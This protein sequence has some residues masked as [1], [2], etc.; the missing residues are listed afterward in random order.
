MK[1]TL[2]K[3][4]VLT[5]LMVGGGVS[6]AQNGGAPA[7]RPPY[8]NNNSY[9]N[10]NRPQQRPRMTPEQRQEQS[11][12][13]LRGVMKE[14]GITEEADQ[15]AVLAYLSDE[16]EARKPLRQM[17]MKLQGAL[18]DTA[19]TDVQIKALVEDYQNAQAV[20]KQRRLKAQSDLDA[21]IHY[22]KNPR[23]EAFLMLMGVLGDGQPMM[24]G[25][26]SP[27]G[28]RNDRPGR[29]PGGR[30]G[31]GDRG[32]RDQGNNGDR[33]G[34]WMQRF[35]KNGDGTLDDQERAQMEAQRQQR[36]RN[37]PG[38]SQGIPTD[39]NN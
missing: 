8:N 3:G 30:G 37:N 19:T 22:T 4:L 11:E 5:G 24:Q 6:F 16:L 15:N 25:R 14:N 39:D 38:H 26:R 2:I 28:G 7:Q 23:M 1:S 35:D 10:N 17:G 36:G 12:E 34:Q 20:E 29:G 33:R 13:R 32:G 9:S 18:G 21:K 31:R 27:E